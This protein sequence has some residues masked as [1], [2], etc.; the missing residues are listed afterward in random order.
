[1][2][3]SQTSEQMNR[4]YDYRYAARLSTWAAQ[5][6]RFMAGGDRRAVIGSGH[7]RITLHLRRCGCQLAVSSPLAPPA[8]MVKRLGLSG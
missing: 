3:W 6:F 4:G 7:L 8:C 2:S 1:M 5:R